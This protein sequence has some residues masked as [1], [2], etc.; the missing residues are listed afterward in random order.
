MHRLIPQVAHLRRFGLPQ[1]SQD[2]QCRGR[3][4]SVTRSQCWLPQVVASS[5]PTPV[6][7]LPPPA[8]ASAGSGPRTARE[9]D[10]DDFAPVPAAVVLVREHCATPVGGSSSRHEMDIAPLMSELHCGRELH[11]AASS[12]V[13]CELHCRAPLHHSAD[14][15]RLIRELHCRLRARSQRRAGLVLPH[16]GGQRGSVR[17]GLRPALNGEASERSSRSPMRSQVQPN[18]ESA[19]AV[20][21]GSAVWCGQCTTD[22]PEMTARWFQW[23][24]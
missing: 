6:V 14:A 16:R 3:G 4:S 12:T 13:G 24:G 18:N 1:L 5:V 11:L 21:K 7:R 23:T 19:Q 2:G 17:R 9:R 10:P 15:G 22:H 8:Y 20:L